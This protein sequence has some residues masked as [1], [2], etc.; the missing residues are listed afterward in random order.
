MCLYFSLSFLLPR[1]SEL[2][3]VHSQWPCRQISS[4]TFGALGPSVSFIL[5][6]RVKCDTKFDV[7]DFDSG[8]AGFITVLTKGG[9]V[10]TWGK[11]MP[12]NWDSE[13]PSPGRPLTERKPYPTKK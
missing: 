3:Q 9:E 4:F 1:S 10:Y 6:T 7:V 2:G 12:V 5:L 8:C 13:T 11:I